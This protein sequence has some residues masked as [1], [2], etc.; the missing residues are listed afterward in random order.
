[1][2]FKSSKRKKLKMISKASTKKIGIVEKREF[3]IFQ[4]GGNIGEKEND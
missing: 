2:K 1:M 3:Q 4:N